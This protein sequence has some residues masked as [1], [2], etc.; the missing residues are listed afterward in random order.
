MIG[1]LMCWVHFPYV[2]SCD[3]R[4]NNQSEVK[5]SEI[6]RAYAEEKHFSSYFSRCWLVP[7]TS[8][9]R[10]NKILYE[11]IQSSSNLT[12]SVAGELEPIT[13]VIWTWYSSPVNDRVTYSQT[14]IHTYTHLRWNTKR[15]PHTNT[16]S[17]HTHII[18]YKDLTNDLEPSTTSSTCSP[19]VLTNIVVNNYCYYIIL[20]CLLSVLNNS[21]FLKLATEDNFT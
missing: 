6:V 2:L 3:I 18:N 21:V 19:C 20:G 9:R 17:L 5:M 13:A 10:P 11:L 1:N 14:S 15:K 12:H 4:L 7:L 16:H 8:T